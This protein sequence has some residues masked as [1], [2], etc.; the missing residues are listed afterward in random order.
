MNILIVEDEAAAAR[1]IK[2]MVEDIGMG[3][4]KVLATLDSIEAT[5]TWLH[6]HPLPDLI[7]MDIELADGQSFE[8]FKQVKITTPVIFTTAY[9]EYALQ[10][11]KVNSI[12][13]LLKP[14]DNDALKYAI[15][16]FIDIKNNYQSASYDIDKLIS[17]LKIGKDYKSRFL[18][19]IG[20]RLIS[21]ETHQIAYFKSEDKVT[22]A[23]SHEAKKYILD[24]T[25]DELEAQTDPIDYFRINRQ[26]LAHY[27]SIGN[28]N[29]YFNGKLKITLKPSTD[30]EVLVS[31]EKA[32][33]FKNWL[34]K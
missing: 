29:S 27:K 9:D 12:D 32:S 14:I 4:Y 30:D 5:V 28:I 34:D 21:L 3:K 19:R 26:Y 22:V 23:Y 10:A 8:I 7:F 6:T 11:F 33:E 31:R 24:H 17:S 1:R 20:D 13:Y 15:D 25:L 2:K 18:V 16:K